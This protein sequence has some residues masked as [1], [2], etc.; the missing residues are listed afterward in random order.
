MDLRLLPTRAPAFP[1][2]LAGDLRTR[3]GLSVLKQ[4]FA[5]HHVVVWRAARRCGLTPD[6]AAA[7]TTDAFRSTASQLEELPLEDQ[8]PF[9]IGRALALA[10]ARL[11]GRRQPRYA[12]ADAGVDPQSLS[13]IE[14]VDLVLARL[15]PDLVEVLVLSDL[16]R[17]PSAEIQAALQ[18][19]PSE[20]DRRLARARDQ[21]REVMRDLVDT[22]AQQEATSPFSS[23]GPPRPQSMFSPV[24]QQS[25]VRG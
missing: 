21:F 16:E 19:A 23:G 3:R 20:L 8:R 22:P 2:T 25:S 24:K 11:P 12:G 15:E 5:M 17:L 13:D 14:L 4:S 10:R 9:L 7:V 6:L 1:G 18:I